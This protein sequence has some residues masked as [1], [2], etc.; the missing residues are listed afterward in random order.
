MLKSKNHRGFVT[1]TFKVRVTNP[2]GFFD[3]SNFYLIKLISEHLT[4]RLPWAS[5][6]TTK[7]KSW[8]ALNY[9]GQNILI[10]I[11][12]LKTFFNWRPLIYTGEKPFSCSQCE[13]KFSTSSYLKRHERIHTGDGPFSCSKC[14]Y[15]SST[16]S[17]LKTPERTSGST[18]LMTE[19]VLNH[20][21]IQGTDKFAL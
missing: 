16:S 15:K 9:W 13:H 20:S 11:V 10:S 7:E 14:N 4:L 12:R 1:E 17:T 18:T 2:K 3:L 8:G 19:I 5:R 21:N 6:L